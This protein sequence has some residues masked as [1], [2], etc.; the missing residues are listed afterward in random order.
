MASDRK[1]ACWAGCWATRPTAASRADR[2]VGG[3]LLRL[4]STASSVWLTIRSMTWWDLGGDRRLDVIP[5]RA[6][7]ELADD[8]A[9][10]SRPL[11][12]PDAVV[13]DVGDGRLTFA[14]AGAVLREGIDGVGHDVLLG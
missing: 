8:R 1:S 5:R 4:A 2:A 6:R 9:D 10:G 7:I 3:S 13:H 12:G 14:L 11:A